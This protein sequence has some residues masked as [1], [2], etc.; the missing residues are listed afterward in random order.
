[1]NVTQHCNTWQWHH[2]RFHCLICQLCL[3]V[4]IHSIPLDSETQ[5]LLSQLQVPCDFGWWR[6]SYLPASDACCRVWRPRCSR[7]IS[8]CGGWFGGQKIEEYS[9]NTGNPTC[10]TPCGTCLSGCNL[11]IDL[12]HCQVG[13]AVS[14]VT[15]K[16][17]TWLTLGINPQLG[18]T[19]ACWTKRRARMITN[20]YVKSWIFMI[21]YKYNIDIIIYIYMYC[22]SRRW[23]PVSP[24]GG[25]RTCSIQPPNGRCRGGNKSRSREWFGPTSTLARTVQAQ[26]S[27]SPSMLHLFALCDF[28]RFEYGALR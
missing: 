11:F 13:F 16:W 18:S 4:Y 23:A 1:M 10:A 24:A 9:T 14:T 3:S 20:T 7:S 12:M 17:P 2:L 28:E 26:T 25:G 8:S 19:K 5:Q 6:I 27:T 22:V 15:Y 21:V